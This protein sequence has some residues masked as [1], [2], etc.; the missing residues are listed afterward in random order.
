MADRS[1]RTSRARDRKIHAVDLAAQAGA[2][3]VASE[4]HEIVEQALL[5]QG[6]DA[7][8]YVEG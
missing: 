2:V 7:Y 3:Q 8:K 1:W 5:E 4:A 6:I